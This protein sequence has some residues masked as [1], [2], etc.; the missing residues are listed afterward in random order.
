[1]FQDV[2]AFFTAFGASVI[3]PVMIFI[4]ALFLKVQ[5]KMAMMSALYAGVGLTGFG[6]IISEFTPVVTKII[7]HMVSTTGI[8]LPVVDIGWQAGSLASFGSTVGLAFFVF[9]LLFELLIFAL[10]ITKVFM[11][12]NLWNNFGFMIWGTMAYYVTHNFWL[13]MGLSFFMLLYSLVLAE[14][15]ADR[16]SD[17]Y[18]VKNATVAAP[19]NIEQTIPAILL[20]PLWN[21]LGFNK[22]KVTPEYFKNKLGVFGEPT[23]LGALLGLII[24]ILGNLHSLGTIKAW[25]QI[26][27]FAVQLAAVMTIF[28]LVTG[29]FAKAFVPLAEEI[30][31]NRK[32]EVA[33][34]GKE[35]DAIH[36]KKRWF[37]GVDDGVGYGEPATIIAGVI[38]IPIMV[39]IA[40]ILPGNRTLPVV[41]LISLPFM[42][43]SIVAVTRGNIL[44]VIANGIVWF[45]LGLYAS[46]WLGTIYTG[47]VSH[48]GVAI[49]AGVVLITSFNLIARPV[50]ALIFAAFISQN[51]VWIGLCI[52]IYLVALYGLRQ[53]R[54]QIWSYLNRMAEKNAK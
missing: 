18:G 54:P 30:D 52:V 16:W 33:E 42:V 17:Y 49:P 6:W 5:P 31:K 11:A 44:K 12:S 41:D 2:N 45:S 27:Q 39:V 10:G 21:L 34:Q 53:Y 50:N 29:V 40:F 14:V 37:L 24:G 35:I 32:K 9:G 51:P 38:L 43:E 15:Q 26:L 13:S 28:P 4:I 23:T 7:K 36:D 25:G 48:Y 3:V 46:S 1:M 19:H 22:V 20:D 47:T 8:K